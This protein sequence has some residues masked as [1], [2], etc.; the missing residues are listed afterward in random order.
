MPCL[1]PISATQDRDG[2]VTLHATRTKAYVTDGYYLELPC[3]TCGTCRSRRVRSWAIRS[4]HEAQMHRRSANGASV[5]NGC[6]ITLTYN[7]Q[8]L[9]TNH[10][11]DVRHFQNFMKKL[12]REHGSGIRFLHCGEYGNEGTR[13][14]HYHACLFGIDFHEDRYI[15]KQEDKSIVWLSPTLDKLWAK[16]FC[17]L[18]PLNFATASYTAGYVIKKMKESELHHNYAVYGMLPAPIDYIKNEYIT[19]SRG[20]RKTKNNPNP[21]GGLGAS[22]FAKYWA[23]VYPADRVHIDGK[24]Y[25]PPAYYDNLLLERDPALHFQVMEKRREYLDD[26]GPSTDLVIRA[27]NEIFAARQSSKTERM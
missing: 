4:H 8:H 16:G 17:T 20:G 22:W 5:M 9:P 24:S 19:M 27:R 25:R 12:R 14:P 3:G 11:L 18:A 10:S 21:I 6:F 26:L 7:N 13:R 1:R 2:T 15:W 23:D